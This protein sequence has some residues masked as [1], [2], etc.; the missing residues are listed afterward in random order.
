MRRRSMAVLRAAACAAAV[1]A[2]PGALAAQQVTLLAAGDVEWSRIVRG[3]ITYALESTNEVDMEVRGV[4]QPTR[5]ISLPLLNVPENRDEIGR[6]LGRDELDSPTAHPQV[7]IQYGLGF[8]SMEEDVRHPLLRIRDVVTGSDLAF[9]NLEMPLSDRARP[10][11]AFR[12]PPEFAEA[13]AWAGFD[14]VS[15]ANN[16]SFDAEELGLLDT[17]DHLDAAG[18]GRIGTGRDLE[19]A[20]RPYIVERN[21]VRIAFLGYARAINGVGS[22]GFALE[23]RSG[24]APMDPLLIRED[25]RRVRDQVDYVAV[26]M[27]WNI[28]NT[29]QTHPEARAFAYDLIDAGA[30]I[31]LGHHPHKPQGVEIYDGRVIFYS[32]GNL[33]FGHGHTYWD[34]GYLARLT[35]GPERVVRVEILPIA[36]RGTDMAQPYLLTG[37]RAQEFLREF[38]DLTADLDTSMEIVGDMGVIN[39]SPATDHHGGG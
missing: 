25:I 11:G 6:R 23:D 18:V 26:S 2:L 21:G 16:H 13:L 5:W 3:P 37:E 36:N 24:V 27:H 19:D 33:I 1:A 12:G 10:T 28:E 38:R 9:A 22:E 15:T 30:D 8:D 32:L 20:R 34:D 29:K 35:L 4:R 17:M 7:S 31:I 14:V 39:V